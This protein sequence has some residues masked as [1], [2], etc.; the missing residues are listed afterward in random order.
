[1]RQPSNYRYEAIIF[2]L[3]GTLIDSAPD[4]AAAVNAYL[5]EHGHAPLSVASVERFIGNGPR[6]LIDDILTEQG[7]HLDVAELDEAVEQYITHYRRHPASHTRFF[8]HVREDLASLHAS[9]VRLGI[10]TNK[11]HALT[12]QILDLLQLSPLVEVALGAD[13]VPACKPDPGHLRAVAAQM[14]LAD[15]T[16]AYVGDTPVDQATAAAAGAP[17]FVVPWGGGSAVRVQPA[18]R[19]QRLADLLSYRIAPLAA[20]FD[21]TQ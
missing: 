2:D 12:H 16:W 10:C 13:A 21:R 9:G 11:P 20:A 7:V 3:D 17:F 5:A 8:P 15:G 19:L 18:Q 4:I 6:R 1:M 14:S